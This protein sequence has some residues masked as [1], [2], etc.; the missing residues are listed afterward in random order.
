MITYITL[1]MGV[2]IPFMTVGWAITAITVDKEVKL[3]V[4]PSYGYRVYEYLI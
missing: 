3:H 1:V 2:I 4:S